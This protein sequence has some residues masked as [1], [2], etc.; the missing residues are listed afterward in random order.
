MLQRQSFPAGIYV[1]KVNDE[2]ARSLCEICSKL[3]IKIL[4]Q[5]QWCRSGVFVVNFEQISHIFL[6]F[7]LLNL[8]LLRSQLFWRKAALNNST[9]SPVKTS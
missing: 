4:E 1:L 6:V 5:R 8:N 9:K 7:P 2:N 3:T